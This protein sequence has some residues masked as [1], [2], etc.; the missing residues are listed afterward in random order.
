MI[1]ASFIPSLHERAAHA[2]GRRIWVVMLA[3]AA[4]PDKAVL[5]PAIALDSGVL[6]DVPV[7]FLVAEPADMAIGNLLQRQVGDF[8]RHLVP[9]GGRRASPRRCAAM[10]TPPVASVNG[11]PISV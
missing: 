6:E 1:E 4:G 7:D 5:R 2:G 11:A 9:G 10:Q 8:G 3:R